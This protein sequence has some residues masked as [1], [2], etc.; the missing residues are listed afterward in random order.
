M[1]VD[2]VSVLWMAAVDSKSLDGTVRDKKFI[3]VTWQCLSKN[4]P[5]WDL[6]TATAYH[7]KLDLDC[8][9]SEQDSMMYNELPIGVPRILHS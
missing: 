2:L 8:A 9:T 7:T 4:M 6:A 5:H 3:Q 1:N